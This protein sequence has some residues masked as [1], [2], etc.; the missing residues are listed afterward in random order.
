LLN[1]YEILQACTQSTKVED[2]PFLVPWLF[3]KNLS[4]D[5]FNEFC[6]CF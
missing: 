6:L 5:N 1:G 2:E 3:G 4:C